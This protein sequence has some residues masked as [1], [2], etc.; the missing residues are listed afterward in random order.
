MGDYITYLRLRGADPTDRTKW[1][2][3]HLW[4]TAFDKARAQGAIDQMMGNQAWEVAT[5]ETLQASTEAKNTGLWGIGT[6]FP[7]LRASFLLKKQAN[8]T[9][10][11]PEMGRVDQFYFVTGDP[12]AS[13]ERPA[14]LFINETDALRYARRCFPTESVERWQ[15]RLKLVPVYTWND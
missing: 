9:G 7:F 1:A 11:Y 12:H 8:A 14:P 2:T 4:L 5:L 10:P 13:E 3:Q 15:Q 6:E